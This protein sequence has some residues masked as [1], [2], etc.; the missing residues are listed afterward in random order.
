MTNHQI[1]AKKLKGGT[2]GNT[3]ID[4]LSIPA[5]SFKPSL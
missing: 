5:L 2:E 1:R 4:D 3:F